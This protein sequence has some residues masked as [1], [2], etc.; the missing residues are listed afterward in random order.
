MKT[1]YILSPDELKLSV[2][3]QKDFLGNVS[4]TFYDGENNTIFFSAHVQIRIDTET[5]LLFSFVIRNNYFEAANAT[6][7]LLLDIQSGD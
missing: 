4:A 6:S 1:V 2:S 7:D 3:N 5:E